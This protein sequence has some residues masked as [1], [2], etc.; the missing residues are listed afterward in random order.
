MFDPHSAVFE[1]IAHLDEEPHSI[2]DYEGGMPRWC[3]GCGNNGLLSAVQRLCTEEQLPPEKT[4]FVSGIGCAARFPHYMNTY[5]FHGLHGRALPVAEGI[6]IMRPDL[7]VFVNT[8]DG[9]CCSIGAGHWLHAIRYNMDMTVMLHD[10]QI[11]GLTKMQSSPT[12]RKGQVS[13]TTPRG[14]RLDALNPLV[15]TLGISNVSFVAQV[16]D[17]MPNIVYQVISK[18]FHHRGFSFIS[19]LQRCP[20]YLPV[21]FDETMK[22]PDKTLLLIHENGLVADATDG[23]TYKNQLEHDPSDLGMAREIAARSDMLPVG[24]LYH[25]KDV[26][27]YEDVIRNSETVSTL[28]TKMAALETEFDKFLVEPRSGSTSQ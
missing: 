23:R 1:N 24:I 2:H 8:G 13:N 4:V 17:W 16:A 10:N 7:H 26:P 12:S 28:E 9:D 15:A 3:S 6:K 22:D 25:N 5:G 19:I 14:A 21:L 27:L 11:Y 18:A 20:A